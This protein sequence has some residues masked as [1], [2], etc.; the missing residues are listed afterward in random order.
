[1]GSRLEAFHAGQ[2]QLAMP[3]AEETVTPMDGR[4]GAEEQGEAHRRGEREGE[5]EAR[6]DAHHAAEG[7]DDTDS[8]REL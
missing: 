7:G 3:T 1:M 2:R 4:A 8:G 5:E 6:R